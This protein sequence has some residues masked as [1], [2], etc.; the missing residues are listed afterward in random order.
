[1]KKLKKFYKEWE[2]TIWVVAM[3]VGAML[4]MGG[5]QVIIEMIRN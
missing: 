3:G 2:I 5:S 4:L 1:M